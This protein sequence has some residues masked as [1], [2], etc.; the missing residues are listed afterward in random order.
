M[1]RASRA[2]IPLIAIVCA[3]SGGVIMLA[4]R[5]PARLTDISSV[6]DA[7]TVAVV[8]EASEPVAYATSQPDPLTILVDVRNVRT[9]GAAV[10][11]GRTVVPVA[12]VQIEP[13]STAGEGARV[14]VQ[15]M[16]SVTPRIRSVRNTIRI[17][18]DRTAQGA[19]DAGADLVATLLPTSGS[20]VDAAPAERVSVIS[21]D[22][23]AAL[24]QME[25]ATARGSMPS[26]GVPATSSGAGSSSAPSSG[27]LYSSSSAAALPQVL[28]QQPPQPVSTP[29]PTATGQA[30]QFSG[31]PVS[32]DFQN[33]DLRSV[34]RTFAEISGLNIVIDPA[35]QG[36]VDVTLRDV[37]WDQALD[38]ILRANKLG[39]TIDGTVVRIAPLTVLAEEEAQRRKLAEEQALSG[40]LRV[41]TRT[42][43]Y[44][45]AEA[46]AQL[47]TRTTLSQRGQ[48]QVDP[49]TNTIIM[50]DLAERLA[51][52]SALLDTLDRPEP[53]VEVEARIVQTSREFA[54]S[55]GVQWGVNGRVSQ[56][57]GNT[58]PLAFPNRGTLTG[59]T[60]ANQGPQDPRAGGF[61][62]TGTAVNLPA[63]SATSAIGLALGAVN[64]AFNLDVALSA[65]ERAGKGRVLSTPRLSTQNNVE[66]E[67]TQ[68]IQIPIQTI[69]NNTVTVTFKDAA[70]TLKVVPQIT[71]AN[72]VIL[73]I[74]LENA[75]PDFSRQVNGIPPI[76]TQ[77]AS[78]QVLV[79]DGATTVIGGIF[80]SREQSVNDRTPGLH[81]IPLLGW[82]FKRDS[83]TDESRELLIF[84][85]PRIIRG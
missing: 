4:S 80:V 36:S 39:Y 12:R 65:L 19:T 40:D 75:S 56:E 63:T 3:A 26:T 70:L 7:T 61:E 46:L 24:K 45:K 38:I 30:K 54:R 8:I 13:L 25:P 27:H 82:L 9:D 18:F 2:R 57:L 11:V 55:I 53:Q 33:A 49:R 64:G 67:V 62:T 74:Q 51:T 48:V 44:A 34:L 79:N 76:D 66:A 47:V 73:R 31:H 85:T 16:R 37:P 6:V 21:L 29:A 42:L 10:R 59:R 17:E 52:A 41:L 35:A 20:S 84:I 81:R 23:M 14:R 58:T 28:P 83:V 5:I 22:P 77:R 50:T 15:L 78:T 32:L 1:T 71:S 60:G 72:T 68:G 43:S 69:A